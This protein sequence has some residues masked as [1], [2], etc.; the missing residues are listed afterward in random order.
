M[1]INTH[2]TLVA[3]V[4]A[5]MGDSTLDTDRI[6]EAIAA[7]E[8]DLNENSDFLPKFLRRRITS[9]MVA[10]NAYLGTPSDFK[11]ISKIVLTGTVPQGVLR[12]FPP[13]MFDML[14]ADSSATGQPVSYTVISNEFKF[15]NKPD[16]A[17]AVEA[18]YYAMIQTSGP[19]SKPDGQKPLTVTNANWLVV[20]RPQIYKWGV[21][22]DMLS[23][24][25]QSDRTRLAT[26]PQRYERAV[27]GMI[28]TNALRHVAGEALYSQPLTPTP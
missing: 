15:G 8:E 18:T 14:H 22:T 12:F 16:S 10:N 7:V 20:N 26:A 2:T 23:Y 6:N 1:A 27:N 28:E 25:G 21:I 19:S 9:A 3:A 13:M 5:E 24:V 11:S 4:R 17:Y